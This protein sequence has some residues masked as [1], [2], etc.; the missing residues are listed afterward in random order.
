M[1]SIDTRWREALH[2][3]RARVAQADGLSQAAVDELAAAWAARLGR[4]PADER[5]DV[6]DETGRPTGITAPRWLCHLLGLRH[7]AVHVLLLA[8]NG[9]F[10][11]QVR[12]PNKA[13]WPGLVDVS[14][15]G[16]LRAGQDYEAAA[17]REMEEELG[18]TSQMLE[19][20][21]LMPVD[22]PRPGHDVDPRRPH[23]VNHQFNQ[24]Y[25]ARLTATA[26]ANVRFHDG[27]VCALYL[28]DE[29]EVDRLVAAGE[30]APGLA[31]AWPIYRRHR[32]Q[33]VA[34]ELA[35]KE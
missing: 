15:G 18:I 28:C 34:G 23:L 35:T 17:W 12:S 8:P 31:H 30:C 19:P 24:L 13:E 29:Q 5:F 3:D 2:A 7:R 9:L 6:C 16:H 26:L 10:V 32:E 20:P 33:F 14:V 22:G 25:V 11:L 1:I 21:G 27:E 4:D